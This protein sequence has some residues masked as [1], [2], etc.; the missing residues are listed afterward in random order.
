MN[1]AIAGYLFDLDGTVHIGEDPVPGA[2]ETL[3]A[4]QER[5][6]PFRFVTN[7]TSKPRRRIQRKLAA[8]G[9]DI[10]AEHIFTA[11]AAA[12]DHLAAEGIT[13]CYFLLRP[14]LLADLPEVLAVDEAPQA[15][16]I[17]DLGDDFTYNKLN[18]A[19]R[20][21]QEGARFITLARNRYYKR[22]EGLFLDVGAFVAALEFA[23]GITAECIGKPSKTFFDIACASMDLPPSRV[24][25]V[26]DDLESDVLGSMAHGLTGIQVETGKFDRSQ[27]DASGRQP[28]R[29]IPSIAALLPSA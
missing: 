17:G 24:A 3:H 26:G 27:L 9:L 19:F 20:F 8:M 16:L 23:T 13:Y 12:A 14:A 18:R 28:D 1:D 11:P 6:T 25:M 15:V 7:T 29:V 10:P 2:V 22:S 5:G 21:I 4:L